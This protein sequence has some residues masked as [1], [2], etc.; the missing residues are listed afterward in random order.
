M[1]I[2]LFI[3]IALAIVLLIAATSRAVNNIGRINLTSNGIKHGE[4]QRLL[5]ESQL[6]EQQRARKGWAVKAEQ[7]EISW[8]VSEAAPNLTRNADSSFP[9]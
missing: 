5:R 2:F 6:Q 3:V 1:D 9:G 8:P 4:L 7:G